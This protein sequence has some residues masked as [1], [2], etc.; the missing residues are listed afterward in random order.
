MSIDE[1]K[2]PEKPIL[3]SRHSSWSSDSDQ[4]IFND[5]DT[6]KKVPE[7]RP[8]MGVKPEVSSKRLANLEV[9]SPSK[10]PAEVP[11]LNRLKEE[12]G[13]KLQQQVLI[14]PISYKQLFCTKSF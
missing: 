5:E 2:L 7:A 10:K 6:T 9:S 11:P 1:G 4:K 14:S 8:E 12:L 3:L 13:K